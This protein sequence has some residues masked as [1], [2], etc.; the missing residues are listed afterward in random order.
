MLKSDSHKSR[1]QNF[2]QKNFSMYENK[3]ASISGGPTHLS[4]HPPSAV[5]AKAILAASGQGQQHQSQHSPSKVMNSRGGGEPQFY[6]NH[7]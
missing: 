6:N 2:N 1:V 3:A 4:H 5:G 7:A